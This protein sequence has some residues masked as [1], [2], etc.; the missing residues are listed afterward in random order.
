M[1]FETKKE[2][3]LRQSEKKW[4]TVGLFTE[5]RMQFRMFFGNINV[6]LCGVMSG[7]VA[8]DVNL[9]L[10][11]H[12]VHFAPITSAVCIL[13]FR[14]TCSPSLRLLICPLSLHLKV[15]VVK[16]VLTL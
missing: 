15:F 5:A 7:Y 1:I 3:S 4:V 12:S 8:F 2:L 13:A 10:Y 9:L 6:F 11:H 14:G 16:V